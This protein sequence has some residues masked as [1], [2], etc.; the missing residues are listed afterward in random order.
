MT[1]SKLDDKVERELSNRLLIPD[2]HVDFYRRR[3]PGRGY[4]E[5]TGRID[6]VDFDYSRDRQEI[7][8]TLSKNDDFINIYSNGKN[9]TEMYVNDRLYHNPKIQQC[10][11]QRDSWREL[12]K[13]EEEAVDVF[14]F[15]KKSLDDVNKHL[16]LLI[17]GV[18]SLMDRY[19]S[20]TLLPGDEFT[21][22]RSN[23]EIFRN[24]S[25]DPKKD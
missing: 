23:S 2:L 12:T 18:V 13:K 7:V 1:P 20:R 4:F 5:I 3:I 24:F 22:S 25:L 6:G 17:P 11:E 9:I 21:D 19:F 14:N 10:G 8:L 16:S 15:G